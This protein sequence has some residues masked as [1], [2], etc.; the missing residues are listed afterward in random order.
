MSDYPDWFGVSI[1]PRRGEYL[2]QKAAA[3]A[4]PAGTKKSL[5]VVFN[6]GSIFGGSFT[7]KSLMGPIITARLVVT[8][9]DQEIF[10]HSFF[11][12]LIDGV[13]A[14]VKAPI[15]L[16]SYIYRSYSAAIGIVDGIDFIVDYDISLDN[17]TA[18]DMVA[19]GDLYYARIT[20]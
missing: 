10:N 12:L 3:V 14:G 11:E 7:F 8:V 15:V 20:G 18:I 2:V 13:V 17:I 4:I 6:K 16:T 19:N 5:A 9:D 1:F